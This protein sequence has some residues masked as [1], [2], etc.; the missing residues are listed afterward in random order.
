ML[1]ALAGSTLLA[2]VVFHRAL[3]GSDVLSSQDY[4]I[5]T[6]PFQAFAEASWGRGD[7]PLWTPH[8]LFGVPFL[9]NGDTFIFYP[10]Q[11]FFWL[12]D[13]AKAIGGQIWLHSILGSVTTYAWLRVSLRRQPVGA[14]IGAAI[15]VYGGFTLSH[16]GFLTFVHVLPW[17][18]LLLLCLERAVERTVIWA[19]W[20]AAVVALIFL[21]GLPQLTWQVLWFLPLYL[22][23]VVLRDRT[24]WRRRALVAI[25]V[26]GGALAAGAAMASVQILPQS[27]LVAQSPRGDG[28]TLGEAGLAA[29]PA[30]ELPTVLLP[31]WGNDYQGEDAA[32]IGV[33]AAGLTVLGIL[34]LGR[35]RRWLELTLWLSMIAVSVVLAVGA[36]TPAF[37]FAHTWLPGFDR[38]RIPSRWLAV[39]TLACAGLASLGAETAVAWLRPAAWRRT[40]ITLAGLAVLL[41]VASPRLRWLADQLDDRRWVVLVSILAIAGVVAVV[42]VSRLGWLDR[43]VASGLLVGL[44]VFELVGSAA[45][46]EWNQTFPADIHA[47]DDLAIPAYLAEH[48]GGRVITAFP[49][50]AAFIEFP[51]RVVGN[52]ALYPEVLSTEGF[53]GTWPTAWVEPYLLS[54]EPLL[55]SGSLEDLS[56]LR[57]L[58]VKYIV[59]R[60]DQ[61]GL[62]GHP[63]VEVVVRDGDRRLL[64]LREPGTRA[65]S[66]CGAAW[67]D[68]DEEVFARTRAPDVDLGQLLLSGTGEDDPGGRCGSAQITASAAASLTVAV[69]L[70]EDGWLFVSDSWYPGW[71]AEVDGNEVPIERAMGAFRAV[72]VPAGEHEV[73]FTYEAPAFRRG[74]TLSAVSM[75]LWLVSLGAVTA[76]QRRRRGRARHALPVADSP[77]AEATSHTSSR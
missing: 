25:L 29:F 63:A 39:T 28:L 12:F 58:G 9:A 3:F 17:T 2:T 32:W 45:F 11:P 33:L 77:E 38:F 8:L 59:A 42:V 67:L 71:V 44:V 56:V 40:R 7:V 48:P 30:E 57:L 27:E 5:I 26:T 1:L 4:T 18:P 74:A 64:R 34:R 52:T 13:S 72:P 43:K 66:Y 41:V 16:H 22:A 73:T 49:A 46:M 23:L 60:D 14:A 51:G 24:A 50:D 15:V 20:G 76:W 61:D 47:T 10:L 21:A 31:D 53:A 6:L 70:P 55:R 68:D 62:L 35:D 75:V 65:M 54:V 69:D 36:S 19:W 37:E